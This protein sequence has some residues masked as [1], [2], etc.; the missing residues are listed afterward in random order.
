MIDPSAAARSRLSMHALASLAAAR[1]LETD[2]HLRRGQHYLRLLAERL[3]E[4][5]RFGPTLRLEGMI[6]LLFQCAPLH[7]IGQVAIPDHILLKPAS[8]EPAEFEVMKRHTTLGGEALERAAREPGVDLLFLRVARQIVEG[9]HE[10][11]DGSGYPHGLAG[12]AIPV[13]ARLMAVADVYDALISRRL[14]RPAMDHAQAAAIL[15]AGSGS[16]FDPAVVEAFEGLQ[17][18]FRDVARAYADSETDI[19][20]RIREIRAMHRRNARALLLQAGDEPSR[21]FAEMLDPGN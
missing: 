9:H 21:F 18:E 1:D 14:H 10:R 3:R 4:H 8:Y 20:R 5:P 7:D 17:T 11:W 12:D 15:F 13:A 6:D 16:H 19:Q 2:N